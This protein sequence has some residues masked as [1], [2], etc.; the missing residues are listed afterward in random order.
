MIYTQEPPNSEI[1]R[2]VWI[3]VDGV[4]D[5]GIKIKKIKIVGIAAAVR[6]YD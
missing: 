3:L 2:V 5:I 1:G 4:R 6:F